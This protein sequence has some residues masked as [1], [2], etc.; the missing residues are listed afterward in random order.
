MLRIYDH[1]LIMQGLTLSYLQLYP[2]RIELIGIKIYI[3]LKIPLILML[4]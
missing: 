1:K 4:I 3:I 2:S